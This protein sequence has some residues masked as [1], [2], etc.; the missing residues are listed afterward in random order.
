MYCNFVENVGVIIYL[1]VNN[2]F[3]FG[4]VMNMINSNKTFLSS[5]FKMKNL[6]EADLNFG[7]KSSK[8][9]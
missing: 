5:E 9:D 3:I 1:F 7:I 6:G 8:F 4:T 2:M